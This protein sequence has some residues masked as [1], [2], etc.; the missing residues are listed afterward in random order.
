MDF[1]GQWVLSPLFSDQKQ[2]EIHFAGDSYVN[3]FIYI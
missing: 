1:N 3:V 2:K